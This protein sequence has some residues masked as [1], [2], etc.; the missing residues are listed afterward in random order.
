MFAVSDCR[1]LSVKLFIHQT[2]DNLHA[3]NLFNMKSGYREMDPLQNI[4]DFIFLCFLV[5]PCLHRRPSS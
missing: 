3:G 5:R 4:P 1:N 2:V